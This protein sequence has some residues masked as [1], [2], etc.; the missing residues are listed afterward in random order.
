MC[1]ISECYS[2]LAQVSALPLCANP[3]F[4]HRLRII[5][6]VWSLL[7]QCM[8][9]SPP[10]SPPFVLGE[11][12]RHTRF[13]FHEGRA[14][15]IA[16]TVR[17]AAFW[18]SFIIIVEFWVITSAQRVQCRGVSCCF[19]NPCFPGFEPHSKSETKTKQAAEVFTESATHACSFTGCWVD[20]SEEHPQ[21]TS[22]EAR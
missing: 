19:A 6:V 21:T 22:F 12:S 4:G 14:A 11:Q 16:T 18:R 20:S 9:G 1:H 17:V 10:R 5:F 3:G 7:H 15:I 2:N 8:H 13:E